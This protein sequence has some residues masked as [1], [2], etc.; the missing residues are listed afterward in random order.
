M[1][2]SMEN[3]SQT[4]REFPRRLAVGAEVLPSRGVHFRVWAPRR[5]QVDVVFDSA[6]LPPLRLAR[7][8][9]GYFSGLAPAAT[10]GLQYRFRLDD[11]EHLYPDPASR[12]QPD[13]PHGSS[14]I[15]NARDFTW[16]DQDWSGI[17][18]ENQVVYEMHVGTFTPEGTWAAAERELPE[19]AELG[20]TCVEVM[21]VAEFPGKFGWGYDGVGLFAPSHLYGMPDDFRRFIDAAHAV[22]VGVILDVVYNHFGPD[23]NYLKEFSNDYFTHDYKTDWGEAINFDGEN[24]G[25]VREFFLANAKYWVEEFHLDGFRFDATQNIYDASREHILAAVSR[26]ARA[27]AGKR[28]IFLVDENDPQHTTIVRSP[29]KGGFGMDALWNDDFHHC[30]MVRLNGCRDT[31]LSN[32]SGHAQEFVSLAKFGH[33]FQGQ[34]Y[35]RNKQRR[36]TPT[37]DL[38]P[39]AFINFLENHDQL[40]NRARG[41]RVH[42]FTS[43]GQYRAMVALLLLAPGTPMLFQGQEFA[44]STPFNYFA[45]HN[46]ELAALVRGGRADYM[47]QFP[48]V[49]TPAMREV[50]DDPSAVS[51]FEKCRLKRSERDEPGHAEVYAMYRDLLKLRKSEAALKG[52]WPGGLDGAVLREDA[53]LLRFFGHAD[54]DR[55]LLVNFGADL[56]LREM[57]EPLMAPPLGK[58]WKIRWS[59]ENP[60]YLGNGVVSMEQ[61]EDWKLPAQSAVLLE[62]VEARPD[63]RDIRIYLEAQRVK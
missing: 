42:Q 52:K 45:D 33:L 6:S 62:P 47:G 16:T 36:G 41:L 49:A 5:Q 2:E 4:A 54:S 1:V 11:G 30:A 32:F 24:S 43:P 23:G 14:R 44:A 28:S 60:K 8:A 59:S 40:S 9:D 50:L 18:A 15:I 63:A 46:S 31:Y 25:S 3:G 39:T 29:D 26:V 37:F 58:A 61:A 20:I 22:G 27:A 19:L 7:E 12:F 35:D 57:A 53:L 55:L 17:T 38:P 51:T 34:S 48:G 10:S 13:G 21:P 56:H